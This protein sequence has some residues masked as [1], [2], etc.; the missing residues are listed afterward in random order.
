V[1]LIYLKRLKRREPSVCLTSCNFQRLFLVAVMLG[2][3]FLDDSYYSNKHWAE[4]G[5]MSTAE[6]NCL[7]LEFLFRLGFSLSLT[8]EEYDSYVALLT[9][10]EQ[11]AAH[12]TRQAVGAAAR[13]ALKIEGHQQFVGTLV[14]IGLGHAEVAAVERQHF[15]RGEKPVEVHLLRRKPHHGARKAVVAHGVVAEHLHVA[16]G[17]ANEAGDNADERALPRPVGA[18]QPMEAAVRHRE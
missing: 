17:P 11:P 9:G 12:A 2:A 7:E 4:V 10:D 16:R 13:L 14:G 6:L 1:G 18:E 15:T 8:R 3:K 5:G